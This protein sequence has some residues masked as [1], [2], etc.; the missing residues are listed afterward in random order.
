M[1][2]TAAPIVALTTLIV[3]ALAHA[4]AAPPRPD[5]VVA[6]VGYDGA[7]TPLV[8][9]T[10]EIILVRDPLQSVG[11]A[12]LSVPDL[13]PILLGGDLSPA[14]MDDAPTPLLD[15]A[16]NARTCAPGMPVVDEDDLWESDSPSDAMRIRAEGREPSLYATPVLSDPNSRSSR[17]LAA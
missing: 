9:R 12:V 10:P 1:L 8:A 4:N 17:L 5:R 6:T 2:R 11:P 13:P 14:L 7:R 3:G 16:A 15:I